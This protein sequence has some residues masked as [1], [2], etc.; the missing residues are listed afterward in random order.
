VGSGVQVR[1]HG[2]E[3]RSMIAARV[4]PVMAWQRHLPSSQHHVC[5]HLFTCRN[6]AHVV[7][8]IAHMPT[9]QKSTISAAAHRPPKSLHLQSHS[10]ITHPQHTTTLL[11]LPQFTTISSPYSKNY[12]S[13][14]SHHSKSDNSEATHHKTSHRISHQLVRQFPYPRRR[15]KRKCA[16]YRDAGADKYWIA[17]SA[18]HRGWLRIVVF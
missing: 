7:N 12:S 18:I 15:T 5:P 11:L 2:V 9:S 13:E 17:G 8:S 10:G 3:P 6:L 1:E 4:H 16:S 14:A